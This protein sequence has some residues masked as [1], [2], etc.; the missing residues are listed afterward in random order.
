M[1]TRRWIWGVRGQLAVAIVSILV[2]GASG[3]S[4]ANGSAPPAT[5]HEAAHQSAG[6]ATG[7]PFE[8]NG[9]R[10]APP[11]AEDRSLERVEP[12]TDSRGDGVYGRFEGDVSFAV[13]A[14]AEADLSQPD[15]TPR[16]QLWLLSRFY[17]TAG[18][19]VSYSQAVVTEDLSERVLAA[20]L[21]IEPLFLFRWSRDEQTGHP[22]FDLVVDSLS[23]SVGGFFAEPRSGRFADQS[24]LELGLGLGIPLAGQAPGPWLRAR[25]LARLGPDNPAGIAQV[26]LE[27]QA[28]WESGWVKN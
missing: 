9:P 19:Y 21:L 3:A 6:P 23:A 1:R 15:F 26:F 12:L 4:A 17:Q 11:A 24:G 27:W 8:A 18:V 28:F 10:G 20:G 13:G 22:F 5:A 16:P 2:L 25:G 7:A 14:G